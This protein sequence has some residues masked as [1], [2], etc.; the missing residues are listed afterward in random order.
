[1]RKKHSPAL[2]VV[3]DRMD[4]RVGEIAVST[5]GHDAGLIFVIIAGIDDRHVLVADG[6]VRKLAAPK[7][8]KMRHLSIFTRL[9]EEDV[10]KLRSGSVNDSFLRKTISSL[11][12]EQLTQS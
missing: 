4:F 3:P 7:K 1:M 10:E 5:A 6:K 8:K 11:D 2:A 12:L 9:S